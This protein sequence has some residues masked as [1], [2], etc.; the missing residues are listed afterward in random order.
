[1]NPAPD[2]LIGNSPISSVLTNRIYRS[3]IVPH[4]NN[5]IHSIAIGRFLMAASARDERRQVTA[6]EPPDKQRPD[7]NGP[8]LTAEQLA[9]KL[10][11]SR[12]HIY[13]LNKIGLPGYKIGGRWRFCIREVEHWLRKKSGL[14]T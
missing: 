11:F 4:S 13:R 1:M 5:S 2:R 12:G 8:Y 3:R 7:D 6:P 10:Q 14:D 9:E